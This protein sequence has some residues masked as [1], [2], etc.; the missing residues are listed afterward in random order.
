MNRLVWR[1]LLL[2]LVL[3]AD[4]VMPPKHSVLL[5]ANGPVYQLYGLNFSP[6]TDGQDPNV[7]PQVTA[8]Q[9]QTRLEIVAPYIKWARSYSMTTGFENLPAIAKQMGLKVAAGAWI[10][11]NTTQN[12]LEINNLIAAIQAGKVDLAIIGSE[13]LL[14]NDVTES[15]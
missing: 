2:G 7:N 12:E 9:I 15:Q 10:G 4:D 13:A 11:P 6:Y 8:A 5:A 14:R 3:L 1:V